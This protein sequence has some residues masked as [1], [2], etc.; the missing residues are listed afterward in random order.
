ME[1]VY[2]AAVTSK[3][4]TDTWEYFMGFTRISEWN[5]G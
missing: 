4:L 3:Q 2:F 1:F 5:K